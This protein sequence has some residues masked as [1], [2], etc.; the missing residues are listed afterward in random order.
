MSSYNN[1]KSENR[2]K[3][4]DERVDVRRCLHASLK[5]V[6]LGACFE[7]TCSYTCACTAGCMY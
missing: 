3:S 6:L 5:N 4:T 1:I 7:C 2:A